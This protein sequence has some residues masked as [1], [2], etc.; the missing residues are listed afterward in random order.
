MSV[1][2][3]T[4]Y[5]QQDDDTWIY[6]IRWPNDC[7]EYD[8]RDAYEDVPRTPTSDCWDTKKV[9]VQPFKTLEEAEKH[10]R[11]NH[12]NGFGENITYKNQR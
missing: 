8:S 9:K 2:F 11:E 10:R 5:E 6:Y 4:H 12:A 7:I 1:N 3:Y